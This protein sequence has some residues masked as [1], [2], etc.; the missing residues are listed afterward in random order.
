M[1]L[2]MWFNG[3]VSLSI[4]DLVAGCMV[5]YPY[6]VHPDSREFTEVEAI[7]TMLDTQRATSINETKI[8]FYTFGRLLRK[9]INIIDGLKYDK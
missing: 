8:H 3:A 5:S 6:Y 9:L 4:D 1:F 7:I 2:T